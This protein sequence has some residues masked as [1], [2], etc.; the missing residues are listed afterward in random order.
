VASSEAVFV[1]DTPSMDVEGA[2]RAGMKAIL[3]LRRTSAV[4]TSKPARTVIKPDKVIRSL[5]ELPKIVEDC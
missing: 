1:G 4:D 3:V 2:K 5:K